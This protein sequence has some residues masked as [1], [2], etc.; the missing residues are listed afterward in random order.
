MGLFWQDKPP[1]PKVK[2][3]SE[4]RAP[5]EPTWLREDYLPGL[6]EARLFPVP[7]MTD[8]DIWIASVNKDR[9]VFDTE[10]YRNYFLAAFRSLATGKV[11]FFER[12]AYNNFDNAK[13]AW[14]MKNITTIGFNCKVICSNFTNTFFSIW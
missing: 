11:L 7:L 13:L 6:E 10:V 14:V 4:K 8:E 12:C 5:P 9:F 1:E 3:E 2:K